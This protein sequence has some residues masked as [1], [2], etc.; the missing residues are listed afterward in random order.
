MTKKYPI[1]T[2][3]T[4]ILPFKVKV[5]LLLTKLP[6]TLFFAVENDCFIVSFFLPYHVVVM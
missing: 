3:L 2:T 1:Y 4:D 6:V 5:I